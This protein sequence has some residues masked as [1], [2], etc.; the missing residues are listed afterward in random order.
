VTRHGFDRL[1]PNG[2]RKTVAVGLS[3]RRLEDGFDKLTPNG[4][5]KTVAVGLSSR[6]F[7]DGFDEFTLN[8]G[9]KTV[10]GEPVESHSSNLGYRPA[11]PKYW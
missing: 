2:Y 1:T 7:E 11:T 10:R 8:R 3:S 6:G 5:R 9:H 4:D